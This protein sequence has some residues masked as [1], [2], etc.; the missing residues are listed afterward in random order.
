MRTRSTAARARL[1]GGLLAVTALG[2]PLAAAGPAHAAPAAPAQAAAAVCLANVH[3]VQL[4]VPAGI[5]GLS[6]AQREKLRQVD[7]DPN[8]GW[9]VAELRL[10]QEL[11]P[12]AGRTAVQTVTAYASPFTTATAG[13]IG[14]TA[15]VVTKEN[16]AIGAATTRSQA[17]FNV[18]LSTPFGA[19]N[20]SSNYQL[21]ILANVNGYFDY[22]PMQDNPAQGI[23]VQPQAQSC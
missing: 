7:F 12:N 1:I 9:K 4:Y 18:A 13:A 23:Y 19:W 11:R 2:A 10:R 15:T 14:A 17:T 5:G 3:I 21:A 16:G 22:A 20:P 8:R 6:S